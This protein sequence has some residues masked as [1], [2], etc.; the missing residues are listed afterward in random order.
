[1]AAS[2]CE[3]STLNQVRSSPLNFGA[4]RGKI[5]NFGSFIRIIVESVFMKYADAEAEAYNKMM[6][7]KA[8]R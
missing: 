2:S 7:E 8:Q 6:E 1:M 4:F 5:I 3:F